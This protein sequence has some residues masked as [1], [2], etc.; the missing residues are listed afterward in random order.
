MAT[1]SV[2]KYPLTTKTQLQF[3]N[4]CCLLQAV[5]VC[6]GS[7]KSTSDDHVVAEEERDAVARLTTTLQEVLQECEDLGLCDWSLVC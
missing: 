2:T 3:L 5:A 7:F 6:T 1:V 4:A